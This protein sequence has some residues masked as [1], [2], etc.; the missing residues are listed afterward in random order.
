[1]TVAEVCRLLN[2]FVFAVTFPAA[3]TRN[4]PIW[5]R[6]IRARASQSYEQRQTGEG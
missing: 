5:Q 1:M 6:T 3:H 2:G 4:W